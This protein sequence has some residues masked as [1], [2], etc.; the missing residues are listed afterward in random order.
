MEKKFDKNNLKLSFD[1]EILLESEKGNY[2]ITKNKPLD[3]LLNLSKD[4]EDIKELLKSNSQDILYFLYNNIINI[5]RI[6]Y[7]IDEIIYF[8]FDDKSNNFILKINH[9]KIEIEKKN[10]IALLFYMSLLIKYNKNL[11]NFSYS[12]GLIKKINSINKN[13]DKST[14]YKKIL[15]SKIILELIN[16]YKSNQIFEEKNN[17]E[18]LNEIE[19]ENNNIIEESINFFVN[20]GLKIAQKD[21]KLKV[22][23][24]LYAEIINIILESQDYDLIE[25]LDLENINITKPIFDEICKTLSLNESF[26]NEYKL[27]TFDDLFDSKKINFYYILFKYILKNSIYIYYIDFLNEERKS[28]INIIH[29]EQNQLK[30]LSN[31]DNNKINISFKDKII[32]IIKFFTNTDYYLKYFNLNNSNILNSNLSDDKETNK[33]SFI[34]LE[35][36]SYLKEKEKS[37]RDEPMANQS[38]ETNRN[39]DE[40]DNYHNSKHNEEISE[41]QSPIDMITP[42][43][44]AQESLENKSNLNQTEQNILSHIE[45]KAKICFMDIINHIFY[46]LKD[47]SITLNINNNKEKKIEY[48]KMIYKKDYMEYF[49]SYEK[50]KNPFLEE[51]N[52]KFEMNEY[53]ILFENYKKLIEYLEKIKEIANTSLSKYKLLIKIDLKEDFIKKNDSCI[54]YIISEYKEN[55]YFYKSKYI[56]ENIL[57]NCNYEGF[58]SFSKEIADSIPQNKD[59]TK[60]VHDNISSIQI[61]SNNIGTSTNNNIKGIINKI[62]KYHFISFEEVIGKHKKIAEKIRELDDDSFISGGYNEIII[63]NKIVQNSK[64]K[65]FE[66][67]FT[68]FIDKDDVIISQKDKFTFFNKIKASNKEINTKFCCRNLL[69]I[70]DNKYIICD[71]NRIFFYTNE[72]INIDNTRDSIFLLEEK[73]KSYRGGIKITDEIIAMTSNSIL[74]KGE[75]KLIFFNLASKRFITEIEVENY[76]FTL[77]ENNCALMKIPNKNNCHLLLFACKKYRKGDKNGILYLKLQLENKE[78]KKFE[79]FYDT[80][81]FEVYC[82]CPILEIKN[83][84]ILG[85][86]DKDQANETEYF[87]VGGFDLDKKEGIIKLFKVIYD[88]EIE[89]IEIK[90]IRDIIIGEKIRKEDP[91]SFKGFKGPIS[92]I[93]QSSTGKILITCYDGNV[94]LFSEPKLDSFQQDYN[95]L[96]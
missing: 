47:S 46:F 57:N 62:N 50:F 77:S 81:N 58:K 56:D 17:I 80:Q 51:Q 19:K 63:Y 16:F 49:I 41:N 23:D 95:I 37:H 93:I 76:S 4:I 25:Q 38:R 85:K 42:A 59:I 27:T 90:Y 22:I 24:L 18:E 3:P 94:Y 65:Y 68:F 21:L 34:P 32:Y 40:D 35:N 31:N 86:N 83:K 82:F 13:I 45:G 66:N 20:I 64:P 33:S 96:K 5:E 11:V 60:I 43:D 78:S 74:S 91:N 39:I 9:E 61:N 70:K 15:I 28:F 12:F 53:N 48:G 36:S 71:E 8:D 75:N 54:K 88:N 10:E 26:I 52:K 73:K 69:K 67:Y 7:N 79:K 6:L 1:I 92:C 2:I 30:N 84:N 87:F 14:I 55:S 44:R 89:K 72:L 29:S